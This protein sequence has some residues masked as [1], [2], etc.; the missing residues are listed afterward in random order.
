M[1]T[2]GNTLVNSEQSI[3]TNG[4]VITQSAATVTYQASNV[5]LGSGF[6]VNKGGTFQISIGPVSCEFP[7]VMAQA[8]EPVHGD[9]D[10]AA[11]AIYP[12]GGPIV[13][14]S[15]EVRLDRNDLTIP[16]RGHIHF[17]LQRRYRSQLDYDGPLGYGWDFTYNEYLSIKAN[18]DVD[19]A[20]GKGRVDTWTRNPDNSYNPPVG[21]FSTLSREGDGRFLLRE[22]G[23]FRRYYSAIGRLMEYQDRFG[24][25]MSFRYDVAG[26][27]VQVKDTYGRVFEFSYQLFGGR[28]RLSILRDFSGR[29]VHYDYDSNGD[30]LTVRSPIVTGTSTANNFPTGRTESY[31]YISGNPATVLNH[32]LSTVTYPEEV[33]ATGPAAMVFTYGDTGIDLDRVLTMIHGGTNASGVPAGGTAL[34]AYQALNQAQP[35][36]NP[37]VHRLQVTVTERNTNQIIYLVNE[38][39]HLKTLR[40]LT[41]GL[42]VGEP[43]FFETN[44]S[45]DDDGQRILALMP[46]GNSIQYGYDS[47]GPR[48]AQRNLLEIRHIADLNRGGGE[49]LLTTFTYEPVFN[50]LATNTDPRGNASGFVPP[51][52][53]PSAARYTTEY[54]YDYQEGGAAIPD[55]AKYSIDLTGTN[56]NLGD[57]N[58]DGRADQLAG[59]LVRKTQ[60][61]VT[62]LADSH[63][64]LDLGSTAQS[65]LT[66]LQWNE[67]GQKTA[68]IDP[69]GNLMGYTYYPENDPDGDAAAI[70]GQLSTLPRGYLMSS[71]VDGTP[72]PPRRTSPSPPAGLETLFGYD[73]VG[74][75]IFEGNPRGVMTIWEVNQLNERVVETLGADVTAAV[76]SGQLLTG[77]AAFS[78]QHRYFYDFNGRVVLLEQENRAA[79][80]TTVGV[81]DWVERSFTY[82]ILDNLLESQ[83]EVDSVTTVSMQRFYDGNELMVRVVEPLNNAVRIEYDERNL[84]FRVY[85]GFLDSDESISVYDYDLN[86]NRSRKMDAQDNDNNALPES[87]FYTYDGFDRQTVTTDALGNQQITYYDVADNIVRLELQGHRA[88]QPLAG[89]VILRD[90]LFSHDELYRRYQ[91][92][93]VLFL[94][95]GFSPLRAENLLDE[96]MDGKVTKKTEYD[97][98][99]RITYTVEDDEDTHQAI[100]DGASRVVQTVD[101]LGN[102]LDL[103]YDR[104]DNLISEVSTEVSPEGIVPD[105]VFITRYVY[106]QLDRLVRTTDNIGRTTR[107]AY[108]SRDNLTTSTDGVGP[109]LGSDPLGVFPGA[110]NGPGNSNT[111]HYD[112]RDLLVK[113]VVDLRVGGQGD[114]ILDTSN[115]SNPDGQVTVQYAFDDNSRL[116]SMTDDNGNTTSYSYDAL[117]RMIKKTNQDS[118]FHAYGYD[119]DDNRVSVTDPNG[120]QITNAFD[121]LNRLVQRN[122]TRSGATLGTTLETYAYDGLSRLTASSDNNGAG[123]THSVDRIY[124]SLSRLLE[125]QQNGEPSSS[126]WFGDGTRKSLT[127]PTTVSL[128]YEYD[129]INRPTRVADSATSLSVGSIAEF[130]WI[131]PGD[132]PWQCPCDGRPLLV[133][134]GNGLEMSFLDDTGLV[135]IG[136]NQ[137]QEVVALRHL[138]AGVPLV[139]RTY[140]YNRAYQR[141]GESLLDV[142]GDPANLFTLDSSYRVVTS[143]MGIDPIEGFSTRIDYELDGVGNREQV[144]FLQDFGGGSTS[145]FG[146][147]YVPNLM[148]EYDDTGAGGGPRAHDNNGNLTDDGGFLYLYDYRNRLVQVKIKTGSVL[149]AAYEYDSYNRRVKKSLDEPG[150]PGVLTREFNY[151][152]DEWQVIEDWGDATDYSINGA[153]STY[154]YGVDIDQPTQLRTSVSAPAGAGTFYYHRDARNN[155]VAM[156]DLA[157]T[158]V[159][160]TRYKDYGGFTQDT[161]IDNPYLFQGRRYD[162]ETGLFYY[163]NRY[164]DPLTGRFLQRD[165]VWDP[166]NMGNQYTFVANGPLSGTDPMGLEIRVYSSEAFFPGSGANHGYVYSTETER[167]VGTAGSSGSAAQD[168]TGKKGTGKPNENK[169][170]VVKLPKGMSE[171]EFMDKIEKW[172]GWNRDIYLPFVNDCQVQLEE[173]FK[174]VG[175]DYP[176]VPGGRGPTPRKFTDYLRREF[177]YTPPNVPPWDEGVE[178]RKWKWIEVMKKEKEA[179]VAAEAAKAAEAARLKIALKKYRAARAPKHPKPSD[180]GPKGSF[181]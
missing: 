24:N 56:R 87:T 104:N 164:Y 17:E 28:Q 160:N 133:A 47:A 64:A 46:E 173:A 148:N 142:I 177:G 86:G 169:Y 92:D 179:R 120:N 75:L 157:G 96:N 19:R 83:V 40:N 73:P 174:Y 21:Y 152:Y 26:N 161:S 163:R 14:N 15:G 22:T 16:G 134:F 180:L 150:N 7:F 101:P 129:E 140:S 13:I 119:L 151:L 176:G 61:T 27:L 132:C 113:E 52:G 34:F 82:D 100:Y 51:L 135:N 55:V 166:N 62:L 77:E 79:V 89:N 78:Y 168:S 41:R 54:F 115:P 4:S 105:E 63:E 138:D 98:L 49:D 20:N 66:E 121:V 50:Q 91:T 146:E 144:D 3:T 70:P 123:T 124:D 32:N 71:V 128:N 93:D 80:S 11:A 110:I 108:D 65:I 68:R 141:I 178:P 165:P 59:N 102:L 162:P 109:M 147:D 159:E 118:T 125:E 2:P 72:A 167:G 42:R 74:N 38:Y 12:A 126:E 43:A 116:A 37:D 1:Y 130:S 131:G 139:D 122:I 112:G 6:T 156:T 153:I 31:S 117:N 154:I 85:R 35:P 170:K 67:R 103:I 48:A 33:A 60:P 155:V 94:A 175:V 90:Q 106:D 171:K 149:K 95:D 81:G 111:R 99:S 145:S 25:S 181:R 143:D 76:S 44:Y 84:L 69:E 9:F 114:G 57:L 127:Y 172:P 136:Y 137:V 5:T 8:Q 10:A 107:L 30:L 39:Q 36:G 97:A 29:E 18:G 158:V 88:G 23:G 58:G 53:A 45:Y